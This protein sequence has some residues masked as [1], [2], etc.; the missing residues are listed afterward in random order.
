MFKIVSFLI[1]ALPVVGL[2]FLLGWLAGFCYSDNI[3]N[4]GTGFDD[5]WKAHKELM[6]EIKELP[7]VKPENTAWME[8]SKV[9]GESKR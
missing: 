3:T 5:G 7:P 2:I 4:W 1:I 6:E 8:E 9:H